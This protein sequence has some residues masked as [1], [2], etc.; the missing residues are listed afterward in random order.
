[1]GAQTGNYNNLIDV[2]ITLQEEPQ[3]QGDMGAVFVRL[4][5]DYFFNREI[6]DSKNL[7]LFFKNFKVPEFIR[8]SGSMLK[9][10]ILDMKSYIDGKMIN[11]SLSGTIMFSSQFLKAHYPQHPPSYAKLPEDIKMDLMDRVKQKNSEIKDAFEKLDLDIKAVK[12]RKV[13][14]LIALILKNLHYMK[15]L[16]FKNLEKPM[17]E[18]IASHF[19]NTD[20][21]F[22]ASPGQCADIGSKGKI[23]DLVKLLFIVRK[24]QEINEIS[25]AYTREFERFKKRTIAVLS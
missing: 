12:N 23:Q 6:E 14:T 1:M 4:L 8:V 19:N 22:T 7:E 17:D 15:N 3:L 16:Q 2:C 11:D 25:E 5:T 21:V 18:L 13:M 10:K 20:V 24:F 9:I